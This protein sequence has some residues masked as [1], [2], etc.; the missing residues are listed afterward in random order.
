MTRSQLT[1]RQKWEK[2][3][4]KGRV[5]YV[6]FDGTLCRFSYPDMG[7]PLPGARRFMKALI[8]RGLK[9]VIL[10]SRMSAEVYTEEERQATANKI[11]RWLTRHNVPYH[12]IDTGNNGKPIGLAYVDDRGVN[13]DGDYN[14]CLRRIDAIREREEARF[15]E[16]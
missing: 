2:F 5:V 8:S 4:E 3:K 7:P 15:D 12:A 6:D 9:P 10:T 14:R 1:S 16:S 11:G 13:F